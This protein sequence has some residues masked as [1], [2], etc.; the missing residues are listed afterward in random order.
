MSISVPPSTAHGG[1]HAYPPLH[2]DLLASLVDAVR[3]PLIVC[4][5]KRRRSGGGLSVG[6]VV[7]VN[8]M[9]CALLNLNT[10]SVLSSPLASLVTTPSGRPPPHGLVSKCTLHCVGSESVSVECDC[11]VFSTDVGSGEAM[12]LLFCHLALVDVAG[13]SSSRLSSPFRRAPGRSG[14]QKPA[15]SAGGGGGDS[16]GEQ[17]ET[18]E[19][20]EEEGEGD[21]GEEGLQ[22]EAEDDSPRAKALQEVQLERLKI[23]VVEDDMM[24]AVAIAELCRKCGYAVENVSSGADCLAALEANAREPAHERFNLVLCDVMMH[25]MDGGEVL[26]HIRRRCAARPATRACLRACVLAVPPSVLGHAHP[27]AATP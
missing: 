27:P 3:E 19:E 23:L 5:G 22:A 16:N 10:E 14:R 2:P 7:A 15:S 8:A 25:G 24:S 1:G 11:R 6:K 17:E 21:G 9:A 26:G 13:S 18:E 4:L 20:T 12:P